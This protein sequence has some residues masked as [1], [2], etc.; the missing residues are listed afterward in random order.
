[1]TLA[2][3]FPGHKNTR[4]ISNTMNENG[5]KKNWKVVIEELKSKHF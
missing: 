3:D 1:M 5:R 2:A 4:K